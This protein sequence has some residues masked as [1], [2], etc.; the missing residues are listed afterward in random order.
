MEPTEPVEGSFYGREGD[1]PAEL[2]FP[3]NFL[4]AIRR[5]RESSA[6]RELYGEPF[7]EMFAAT[8]ESQ[9]RRFR[10]LVTDVER[11]HFFELI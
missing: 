2:R 4:D 6:A 10:G 1:L 3:E 7:V 8:R 9:D 11:R 5:F